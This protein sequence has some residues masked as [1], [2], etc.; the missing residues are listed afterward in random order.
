MRRANAASIALLLLLFPL[1]ITQNYARASPSPSLTLLLTTNKTAYYLHE[2]VQATT[3]FLNG[4]EPIL[5]GSVTLETAFPNATTWFVWHNT[6]DENG[7]A[8]FTFNLDNCPQGEYTVYATGYTYAFGNASATTKFTVNIP[9][10]PMPNN[11]TLIVK[12][13][14]VSAQVFVNG[15]VW[16]LSPQNRT[17]EPGMYTVSYEVVEG[18]NTPDSEAVTVSENQ[19]TTVQGVY[20]PMSGTALIAGPDLI[21]N[22]HPFTINATEVRV[23]LKIYSISDPVVIIIRNLTESGGI[24]VPDGWTMLGNCVQI[25]V[26]NTN[27]SL[28]ATLYIHFDN[29]DLSKAQLEENALQ[30]HF[31][32]ITSNGWS[33]VETGIDEHTQY[34]WANIDHFSTWTIIGRSTSSNP[35]PTW[36]WI[37]VIALFGLL[38]TGLI[39]GIKRKAV[40]VRNRK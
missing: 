18:F 9:E 6:T 19:T 14:P 20:Q 38:A 2:D 16:G 33:P 4:T 15:V 22:T 37:T 23:Y 17:L 30:I 40:L 8:A 32:N 21:N 34:A 12:T 24:T 26:N 11:G 7:F 1:F 39:Y 31:W 27:V 35:T 3:R 5:G 13:T 28:N 29:D 25:S 36:V 10:I